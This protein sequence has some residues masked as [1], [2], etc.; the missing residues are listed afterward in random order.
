MRFLPALLLAILIACGIVAHAAAQAS[1][2][3]EDPASWPPLLPEFPS[4]GGGGIVIRGYQPVVTGSTCTT[5]FAAVTPT[6]E[7]FR[8]VAEFDAVPHA[9]GILCTNGRWRAADGSASGTTPFRVFL[10]DG[11]WRMA[12]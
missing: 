3:G 11:M 2:M 4:T 6:G 10:K 1:T 5:P 12:P 7:V 8:N 9:G